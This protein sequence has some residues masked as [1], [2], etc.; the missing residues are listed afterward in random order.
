M[1][2]KVNYTDTGAG[3]ILIFSSPLEVKLI[4]GHNPLAEADI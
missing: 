2:V 1:R 3:K 4:F